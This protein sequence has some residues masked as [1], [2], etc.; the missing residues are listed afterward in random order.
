VRLLNLCAALALLAAAPAFAGPKAPSLC[1][2]TQPTCIAAMSS[3]VNAGR[4]KYNPGHYMTPLMSDDQA[5]LFER[6]DEVC[7]EPSLKGLQ[8]RVLW[9]AL[10]SAAGEYTFRYVVQVYNRLAACKKRLILEVW[11]VSFDPGVNDIV[12]ADL[13]GRLALT[14]QG[15]IARLWETAVMDRL[16]ALYAA[17]GQRFDKE[18]YFEGIIVTETAT[19]GAEG[20]YTPAKFI[21]QLTRGLKAIRVAW[22][23]S[24]VILY[25][26]YLPGSTPEEAV[27]FVEMLRKTGVASGG[28]DVLPPPH[29]GTPGERAFRGELGGK[30]FRGRM[31]SAFSVQTPELGGKEGDFT[32]RE[33]F[34]H[35]VY[36]N[37]C[38]YMFW[39]R[40]TYEGGPEQQWSTGIL[41][42][43]RKNPS[44]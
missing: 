37:K 43:I 7:G 40:N 12:P 44:L 3:G 39:A 17:L 14:N 23:N 18:P 36:T 21:W 16:V 15:Y 29:K 26:N 22:P 27:A 6:V 41:P 34:D 5:A 33:L 30:D 1:V 4:K 20:G 24:T 8:L 13:L 42:F 2:E 25:N 31:V 10:E 32:P 28:P 35:C 19:G 9:S 11:A 38:R